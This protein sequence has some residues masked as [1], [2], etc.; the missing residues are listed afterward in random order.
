MICTLVLFL[1]FRSNEVF[2][3]TRT[4]LDDE[5]V[6]LVAR[7]NLFHNSNVAQANIFVLSYVFADNDRIANI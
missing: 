4:H 7:E 5:K 6:P 3:S 2:T 1:K